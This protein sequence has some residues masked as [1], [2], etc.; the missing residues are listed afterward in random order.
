[1]EKP[2]KK[3]YD[4]NDNIEGVRFANTMINYCYELEQMIIEFAYWLTEPN[5]D[6]LKE[7]VTIEE[8]LEIYKKQKQNENNN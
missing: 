5:N 2:N 7:N 1:M 8:L 3:D 6:E 4:F